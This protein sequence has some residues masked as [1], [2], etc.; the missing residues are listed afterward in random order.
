MMIRYKHNIYPRHD[1]P[2]TVA[3]AI[4]H[5]LADSDPMQRAD[6]VSEIVGRLLTVLHTKGILLP[7]ELITVLGHHSYE[8]VSTGNGQAETPTR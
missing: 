1:R 6:N 3:G 8:E 2:M 4:S 5:A 7:A